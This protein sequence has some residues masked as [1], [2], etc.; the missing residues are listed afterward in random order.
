MKYLPPYT[1]L[2]TQPL[3]LFVMTRGN[4]VKGVVRCPWVVPNMSDPC[5][6]VPNPSYCVQTCECIVELPIV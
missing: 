4:T 1:G 2:L 5:V 6:F 3:F